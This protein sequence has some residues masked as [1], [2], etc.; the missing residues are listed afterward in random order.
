MEGDLELAVDNPSPSDHGPG[1]PLHPQGT[2]FAQVPSLCPWMPRAQQCSPTQE[3]EV[4]GIW[5]RRKKGQ[6]LNVI[7][8]F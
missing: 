5:M 2:P 4:A 1:L 8:D 7:L 6:S 3:T